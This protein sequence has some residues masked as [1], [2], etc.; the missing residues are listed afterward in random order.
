MAFKEPAVDALAGG[1]MIVTLAVWQ[2]DD[3]VKV[4]EK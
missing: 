4:G 3:T 2:I 1:V